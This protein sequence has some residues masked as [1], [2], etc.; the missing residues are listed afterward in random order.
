MVILQ[1][2]PVPI[3]QRYASIPQPLADVIDL[4]LLDKPE[5]H[6][7][8]AANFKWALLSVL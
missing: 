4:A 5:I 6:F 2:D 1:T 8:D 3:H 7:K